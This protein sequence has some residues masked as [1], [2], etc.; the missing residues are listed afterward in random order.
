[1][2]IPRIYQAGDYSVGDN[3]ELEAEA[4]QHI[5]TVLRLK[6]GAK[7]VI[8]DGKG[9]SFNA[10]ILSINKKSCRITLSNVT[11]SEP[12]KFQITLVQAIIKPDKM[13]LIMQKAVELGVTKIIPLITENCQVKLN[14]EN[15]EKKSGHWRKIIVGACEQCGN[16]FLP[17]L[18]PIGHINDQSIE[19]SP[20]LHI[21]LDPYAK[22]SFNEIPKDL[23]GVAVLIGPEGGLTDSE[24]KSLQSKENFMAVRLGQRILRAETAAI[25]G[26]TLCQWLNGGL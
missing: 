26:I 5:V 23:R 13:D 20:M 19:P 3:V 16:N 1:M 6:Q 22:K 9:S 17:E 24:I 12:P 14:K 25:A 2:R 21:V 11:H 10:A 4:F 18:M 7:L 8:F 15:F